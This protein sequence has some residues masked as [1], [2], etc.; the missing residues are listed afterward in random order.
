MLAIGLH[1]IKKLA[2]LWQRPGYATTGD[3]R[4]FSKTRLPVRGKLVH[5]S[6]AVVLN[7]GLAVEQN[8]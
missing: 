6:R 1:A 2:V 8:Y 4:N 3:S 5:R 7:H